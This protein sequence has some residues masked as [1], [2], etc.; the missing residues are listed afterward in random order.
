MQYANTVYGGGG[1]GAKSVQRGVI[2][3]NN[4]ASATATITA[5]NPAK[6]K[7]QHL[8]SMASGATSGNQAV[9]LELTGASTVTASRL[10]GTGNCSVSWELIEF[11]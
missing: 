10:T 1:G 11:N 8:G 5:V 9:R 4:L 3:L 2:T 7:L 6:T